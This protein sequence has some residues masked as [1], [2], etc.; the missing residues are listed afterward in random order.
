M[1][2]EPLEDPTFKRGETLLIDSW[3]NKNLPPHIVSFVLFQNTQVK[4]NNK[5]NEVKYNV[6]DLQF[7]EVE[8]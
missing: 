2:N 5:V 4:E 3:L 7:E 1:F 6:S 8:I